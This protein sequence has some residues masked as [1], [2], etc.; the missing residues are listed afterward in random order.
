MILVYVHFRYTVLRHSTEL[1]LHTYRLWLQPPAHAGSS[2]ADFSTL[3]MEAIRSSETS[4]HTRSTRR[5]IPEDGIL[6]FSSLWITSPK[7]KLHSWHLQENNGE[8][9]RGSHPTHHTGN[10]AEQAGI[11][12]SQSKL[13][14]DR[15][16]AGQSVL[17]QS[18][19]LGLTTR[20][21][22]LSDSCGFVDLG[23]PL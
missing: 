23:R 21:C 9:T 13:C 11:S 10:L 7:T 22:L 16:S 18:T 15:R 19:H 20:S 5:H 8:V 2:L 17:E 14:Y 3:K 6:H 1:T 4:V 12:K